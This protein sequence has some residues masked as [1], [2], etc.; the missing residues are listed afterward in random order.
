MK[1][2]KIFTAKD[3]QEHLDLLDIQPILKNQVRQVKWLY[4]NANKCT[5]VYDEKLVRLIVHT[6][7]E[8]ITRLNVE[9]WKRNQ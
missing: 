1:K 2:K 6:L 5:M 4:N 3:V 8:E 9:I 7:E